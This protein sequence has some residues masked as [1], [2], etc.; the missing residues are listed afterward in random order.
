VNVKVKHYGPLVGILILAALLYGYGLDWGIASLRDFRLDGKRVSFAA[1]NFHPDSN[2]LERAAASLDDSIYPHIIRDGKT[3]LFSSYGTVFIYTYWGVVRTAGALFGFEPFGEAA[4]DS[5]A[6]RLTGRMI[7]ALMGLVAVWL[8]FC[9]GRLSFGRETGLLA[10]FLLCLMPM[11]IQASHM[12][13][14]DGALALGS[15]WICYQS[16]VMLKRKDLSAYLVC[17]VAA[18]ITV[19][20]KLNAV[21]LLAAPVIAHARRWSGDP[22]STGGYGLLLD[23]RWLRIWF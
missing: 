2:A 16:I 18:G 21:L 15:V 17:G 10:A 13:T 5:D 6:T 7:S 4:V 14:V 3:F 20:T 1:A 23:A 19:A 22:W 12:A 11:M 8:T 9:A